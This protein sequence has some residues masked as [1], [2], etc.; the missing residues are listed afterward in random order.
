MEFVTVADDKRETLAGG[1]V[2]SPSGNKTKWHLVSRGPMLERWAEL[3]TRGAI[4]Y[5]ADNWMQALKETDLVKRHETKE[6]FVE[7]A[8]RHFN[9][10]L[11][12]D[13]K[14]DHAAAVIFN[15]NGYEAMLATDRNEQK[16]VNA[17]K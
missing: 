16:D 13:R 10:W 17:T 1:M 8:A 2:R 6:R 3:L 11:Q 15:L 14:E 4:V 5:G 7:S 12:G 9:Q